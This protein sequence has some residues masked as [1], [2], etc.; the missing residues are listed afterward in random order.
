MKGLLKSFLLGVGIAMTF[1]SIVFV[2]FDI[3][4]GGTFKLEDYQ[5]TKMV[6]GCLICGAGFGIPSMVY[7]NDR[8][9]MA[10]KVLIHMGI[11]CTVYTIVAFNVGWLGTGTTLAQ[12]VLIVACQLVCSFLIWFCFMLH[13]KKEARKMNDRLHER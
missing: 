6:I 12:K 9:S 10:T 13:Y 5:M 2:V 7:S 4:N 1:M 3:I 8:L 11:G